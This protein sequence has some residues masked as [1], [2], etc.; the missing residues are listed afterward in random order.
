MNFRRILLPVYLLVATTQMVNAQTPTTKPAVPDWALPATSTHKQVSPP[1]DFHREA[2][3]TIAPIGIF[4]GQ[5]DVGAAV[6]PGSSTYDAATKK[7]TI[8]SAGYNIWYVRD[9][10]RY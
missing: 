6:I 2:K 3:T 5:S 8:T 10:F 9:E 1:A 4:D 7:Y